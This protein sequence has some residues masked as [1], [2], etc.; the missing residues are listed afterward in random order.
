[1][2]LI[3]RFKRVTVA[4]IGDFMLDKYIFGVAERISPEAPV[5]IVRVISEEYRLGGAGN[6]AANICSL[7]GKARIV[8]VIGDDAAG[9]IL[10]EKLAKFHFSK[11]WLP[12][13]LTCNNRPT[14]TKTRIIVAN[15]QIVR[16]DRESDDELPALLR[17]ILLER[18]VNAIE[19]SDIV[20]LSDYAKGVIEEELSKICIQ[21]AGELGKPILIDPKPAHRDYYV[22]ATV[23]TPNLA[24]AERMTGMLLSD[25]ENIR[26]AAKILREK[27]DLDAI[28]VTRGPIGMSLLNSAG[29]MHIS[30]CAK[31]VYDIIG[32]G[33]TV[34]ATM[35]LCMGARLAME[36][37]AKIAN[38][39]AGIVVGKQGTAVVNESELMNA[40]N[41]QEA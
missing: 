19:D 18:A 30:S 10:E 3:E 9:K 39:A 21:K 31:Q 35:A 8:G 37:S 13:M 11:L 38:I 41:K 33:D 32:A 25:N 36:E 27:L 5:P 24:E 17:K 12:G 22:S 40:I 4:V 7:G 26:N 6:V 20:I 29:I 16:I 23:M 1:M 34:I 2:N 15:Q 14:T 28:L